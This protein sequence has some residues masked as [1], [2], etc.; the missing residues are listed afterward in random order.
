[1]SLLVCNLQV[2]LSAKCIG[3]VGEELRL[4]DTVHQRV[5]L[6]SAH[7]EREPVILQVRCADGLDR[8]DRYRPL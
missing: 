5:R 7:H 3:E 4:K 6:L 8:S 2:Q 1:M